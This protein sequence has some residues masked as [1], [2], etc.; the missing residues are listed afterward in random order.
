M[1]EAVL[2][3]LAMA[4]WTQIGG[5]LTVNAFAAPGYGPAPEDLVFR[6]E[7]DRQADG[8]ST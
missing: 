2:D 8:G 4:G 1:L 7:R 3:E 5:T 6:R